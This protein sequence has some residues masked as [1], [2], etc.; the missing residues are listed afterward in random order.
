MSYQEVL[1]N[2]PSLWGQIESPLKTGYKGP[3]TDSRALES[4]KEFYVAFSLIS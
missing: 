3:D 4:F 1:E 2:M